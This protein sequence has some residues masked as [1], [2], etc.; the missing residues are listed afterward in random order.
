MA[1]LLREFQVFLLWPGSQQLM[2][3]QLWVGAD[4]QL[5][6]LPDR[7]EEEAVFLLSTPS[8]SI[9]PPLDFAALGSLQKC[10]SCFSFHPLLCP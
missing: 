5:L 8:P 9:V 2:R 7:G 10:F 6:E 4:K 1:A 3:G